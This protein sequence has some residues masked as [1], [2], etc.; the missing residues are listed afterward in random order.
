[1]KRLKTK[2]KNYHFFNENIVSKIAAKTFFYILLYCS[3]Q[4]K[5]YSACA[6][7]VLW[8]LGEVI[9]DF[10]G[11][12]CNFGGPGSNFGVPGHLGAPWIHCELR[13][14]ILR[15]QRLKTLI[16]LVFSMKMKVLR[17]PG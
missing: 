1:M 7:Q 5:S 11:P 15:V 10:G 4:T 8:D 17:V 3:W 16:L 2:P 9:W 13:E 14:A 12:G 6:Q